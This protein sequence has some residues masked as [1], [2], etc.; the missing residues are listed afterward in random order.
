M[1]FDYEKSSW[2]GG[3]AAQASQKAATCCKNAMVGRWPD[4]RIKANSIRSA[5]RPLPCGHRPA[6]GMRPSHVTR[7]SGSAEKTVASSE[8]RGQRRCG[9][10]GGYSCGHCCCP[11]PRP[12]DA[13]PDMDDFKVGHLLAPVFRAPCPPN[14]RRLQAA[15]ARGY[16]GSG[17]LGIA[18]SLDAADQQPR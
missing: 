4:H 7:A 10:C 3:N 8:V 12:L 13:V 17:P 18:K 14:P 16:R 6:C 11:F 15:C 1:S 5:S 9:N 2:A